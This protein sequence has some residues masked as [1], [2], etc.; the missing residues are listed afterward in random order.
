MPLSSIIDIQKF[1]MF[2]GYIRKRDDLMVQISY[3]EEEK[4]YN[5]VINQN[6]KQIG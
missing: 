4:T 5:A 3:L 2:K 6:D 1:S